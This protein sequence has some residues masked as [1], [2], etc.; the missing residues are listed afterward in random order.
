[1]A[2]P[3]CGAVNPADHRFCGQCG[4]PLPRTCAAYGHDNPA[5]NRFC[6]GCGSPL[7]PN[8]SAT[9]APERPVSAPQDRTPLCRLLCSSTADVEHS[10]ERSA[11]ELA[12]IGQVP[13]TPRERWARAWSR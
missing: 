9:A 8:A 2:C 6:G 13:N 4:A 10:H 1:M 5:G 7:Q 3:S 11:S 12:R